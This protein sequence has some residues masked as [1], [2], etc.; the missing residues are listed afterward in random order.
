MCHICKNPRTRA[1]AQARARILKAER[2]KL[3]RKA[4]NIKALLE[5]KQFDVRDW[6]SYM[7]ARSSHTGDLI[8]KGRAF[9]SSTFPYIDLEENWVWE[10]EKNV[11]YRDKHRRY[12]FFP[13]RSFHFIDEKGE[14]DK[15]A[16]VPYVSFLFLH[17]SSQDLKLLRMAG[18]E[19]DINEI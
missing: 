19:V 3:S 9:T 8:T 14:K 16:I 12:L 6:S 17:P 5:R 11:Y 18:T 15:V 7:Y 1:Q 10:K 2:Q 13:S 4:S